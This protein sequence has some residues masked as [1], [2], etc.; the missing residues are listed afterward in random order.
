MT[1]DVKTKTADELLSKTISYLRFPLTV[2]VIF[3]HFDLSIGLDI[4]GVTYGLNNPGWYFFIINLISGT[5]AAISVPLFI[6]ISGFLFFYSKDFSGDVYK[7]KLKS[8]LRTLL[9]PYILWNVIAI[10][11][12]LKCFLP[13][14]SAFYLPI[15]VQI[16]PLRVLSTF[17]CNY[18]GIFVNAHYAGW[19]GII[20]PI[21]GPLWFVR[22]LM[23]MVL[24]TPLFHWLIKKTGILLIGINALA[25]FLSPLFVSK[26]SPIECYISI[27]VKVSFFF[28]WGAYYSIGKKNFV[29]RFQRMKYVPYMYVFVAIADVLTNGMDYNFYIHKVGIL[30]GVVSIVLITSYLLENKMVKVNHTLAHSSF[31]IFALHYMIISVIGKMAFVMLHVS[32][33]NSYEMLALY[34][35]TAILT[36]L[37]C[38]GLYVLLRRCTPRVCNV[39]T[40]GR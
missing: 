1:L 36:I 18:N 27:L 20:I 15:E 40:G 19:R 3:I 8:R 26:D 30:L 32:D 9:I 25:W 21:D 39:L 23:V 24:L 16:S 38:L 34:F 28:S 14:I 31:F 6:F 35:G 2:G 22:D 37:I 4:K 33:N 13:G 29:M 17:L 12:Q 10:L 5:L 7:Q 11:W